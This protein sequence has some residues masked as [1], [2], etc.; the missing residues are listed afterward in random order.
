MT[1]RPRM[2]TRDMLFNDKRDVLQLA[3]AALI[4]TTVAAHAQDERPNIILIVADDLGYADMGSFGG[5]I[6]T[7]NL[8]A[9]AA[10]GVRFTQ[11]MTSATC[12]PV[13]VHVADGDGQSPRRPRQHGRVR[14]AQSGRE[15]RIRGVLNDRVAPIPPLLQRR[16]TT[17]SWP[18]S[19]YGRRAGRDSG[20]PRISCVTSRSCLAVEAIWMTCGMRRVRAATLHA[21]RN[22]VDAA[23]AGISFKRRLH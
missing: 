1:F 9:L 19:A 3:F 21:E 17:P 22:A 23:A 10:E 13:A 8:D 2:D 14:G 4:G 12:S 6:E 18:A 5:E 15:P 11:F 20:R 16:D 7:P